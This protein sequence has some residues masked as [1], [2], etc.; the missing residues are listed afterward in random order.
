MKHNA[1]SDGKVSRVLL[2]NALS[3]VSKTRGQVVKYQDNTRFY[4]MS[5][6]ENIR[7]IRNFDFRPP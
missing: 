6:Q 1:L 7:F 5:Y 3:D 4:S 2:A